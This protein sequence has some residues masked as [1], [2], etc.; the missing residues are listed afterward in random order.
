VDTEEFTEIASSLE[1][2]RDGEGLRHYL[3]GRP[4][5]QGEE[6]ELLLAEGRWLRGCYEWTGAPVVWPAFRVTLA[7]RVSATSERKLTGALPL[8]PSARLRWPLR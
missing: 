6:L 5:H 2:R 1:L 4:V 8:P 7:G 3:A